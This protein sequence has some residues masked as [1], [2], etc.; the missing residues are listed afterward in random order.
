MRRLII[1]CGLLALLTPMAALAQSDAQ[2][3]TKE[4]EALRQQVQELEKLKDRLDTLERELAK[5]A[6]APA[7][8]PAKPATPTVSLTGYVQ[9]RYELNEARKPNSDF[10]LRRARLRLLANPT[11]WASAF[12]QLEGNTAGVEA[13]DVFLDLKTKSGEFLRAGQFIVPFGLDTTDL[14]HERIVPEMARTTEVLLNGALYD[15][16]AYIGKAATSPRGGP[17][18]FVGTINGAGINKRDNNGTKDV[19][20]RVVQPFT[21]GSLGISGYSGRSTRTLVTGKDAAGK[22]ITADVTT[23][24]ERLGLEALAHFGGLELR[25]EWLRGRDYGAMTQGGYLT[26]IYRPKGSKGIPFLRFDT[27]DPNVRGAKDYFS[28]WTLGYAYQMAPLTRLTFTQEFIHDS[29]T[30]TGDNVTTFQIQQ[31]F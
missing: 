20:A 3:P 5:P 11:P 10:Y 22:D 18:F 28:R 17:G 24:K 16:G 15:R 21:W 27:H 4:I 29:A 13:R 14:P 7:P 12:I 30:K 2:D 25:G 23:P 8:A 6:A 19:V 31:R 9:M 26:G 1:A